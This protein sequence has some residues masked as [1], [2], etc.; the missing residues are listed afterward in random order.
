MR[1]FKFSW[2]PYQHGDH[3]TATFNGGTILWVRE[4]VLTRAW[5]SLG[6]KHVPPIRTVASKNYIRR[7]LSQILRFLQTTMS[8]RRNRKGENSRRRKR[9]LLK[10]AYEYGELSGADIAIFI[11]QSGRW[12][13]YRSTDRQS[14][15]PSWEQIVS[16]ETKYI[17][18]AK[19]RTA[20]VISAS[21]KSIT[22]R[23]P[24]LRAGIFAVIT[25]GTMF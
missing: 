23:F 6:H 24:T 8:P 21:G 3:S 5:E 11:Y 25:C 19:K 15:P 20:K 4:K 12:F 13:T 9:T 17:R 7:P 1:N 14:F 22:T 10:K 18:N 2:L 16:V